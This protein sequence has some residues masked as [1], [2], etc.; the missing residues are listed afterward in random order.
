MIYVTLYLNFHCK[1]I[2]IWAVQHKLLSNILWN[3]DCQFWKYA[4][5]WSD[6]VAFLKQLMIAHW[7]FCYIHVWCLS[8]VIV[9]PFLLVSNVKKPRGLLRLVVLVLLFYGFKIS[10]ISIFVPVLKPLLLQK[11]SFFFHIHEHFSYNSANL[12][13]WFDHS[14]SRMNLS[15]V[16]HGETVWKTS[17]TSTIVCLEQDGLHYLTS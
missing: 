5:L 4:L 13:P 14:H 17:F 3:R 11:T 16:W 6:F 12:Q 7:I 10:K 9:W 15:V 2:F 1:C 8:N